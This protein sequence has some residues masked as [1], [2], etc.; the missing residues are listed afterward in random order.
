MPTS[1]EIDLLL[2]AL[3]DGG[4]LVHE[5]P[6]NEPELELDEE[7]GEELLYACHELL[8]FIEL[9][10]EDLEL[11]EEVNLLLDRLAAMMAWRKL[12]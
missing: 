4:Q 8:S 2:T 7:S 3:S 12:Q 10:M 9:G 11:K 5:A 6:T 1:D